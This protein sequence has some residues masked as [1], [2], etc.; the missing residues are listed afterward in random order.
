MSLGVERL[1]DVVVLVPDGMLKGGQETD[2]LRIA[3]W[4]L[5]DGGEKKILLDLA[6]T[7]YM[8]S[9]PFGLLASVHRTAVSS[10]VQLCVCNVN[11]RIQKVWGS[12]LT[13]VKPPLELY[14]TR[15]EALAA[16]AQR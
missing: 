7:S 14:A 13:L 5:V 10:D 9:M 1:G 2:E 3:L 15:A 11:E 6:R 4:K 8:S 16:L 12:I